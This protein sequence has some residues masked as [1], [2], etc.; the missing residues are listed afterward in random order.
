MEDEKEWSEG[1]YQQSATVEYLMELK[2][3]G[4][5]KRRQRS[6]YLRS[7]AGKTVTKVKHL[8]RPPAD[9]GSLESRARSIAPNTSK[10]RNLAAMDH[11]V[12]YAESVIGQEGGY[13]EAI[14]RGAHEMQTTNL[15]ESSSSVPDPTIKSRLAGYR[16][17]ELDA[18]FRGERENDEGLKRV[19]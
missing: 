10:W 19:L 13:S 6:I 2:R 16:S 12:T 11:D 7:N 17:V 3:E 15:N 9:C 8:Q 18:V 4:R 14:K 5:K 1:P